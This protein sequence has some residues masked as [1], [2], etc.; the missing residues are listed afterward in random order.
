MGV[1]IARCSLALGGLTY[2][3][4]VLALMLPTGLKQ[5]T[6]FASEM[7][8]V[9]HPYAWVFRGADL[10]SGTLICLGA[11]AGLGWARRQP[12]RRLLQLMLIATAAVGVTLCATALMP[13]DCSG[14]NGQCRAIRAR[15][16]PRTW[17]DIAHHDISNISGSAFSLA[18]LAFI[19]LVA[20]GGGGRAARIWVLPLLLLS[21]F[22]STLMT[23]LLWTASTQGIPQRIEEAAESLFFLVVAVDIGHPSRPLRRISSSNMFSSGRVVEESSSVQLSN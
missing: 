9:G 4:W 17:H 15:G 3:S 22:T 10:L 23:D 8:A 5:Q 1:R 12:G 18:L 6:A 2:S 11:T 21:A 14:S 7:E 13:V 20:L 19:V 16:A